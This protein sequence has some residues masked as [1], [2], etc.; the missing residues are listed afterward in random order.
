[1]A[2]KP[3]S[4]ERRKEIFLALVDARDHDMSVAQSRRHIVTHFGIREEQVRRIEQEG[5]ENDWPP[6]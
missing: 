5:I 3:L 6:L 4:E 2:D 1:M